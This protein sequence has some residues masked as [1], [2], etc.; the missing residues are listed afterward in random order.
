M[1]DWKTVRLVWEAS[2]EP[3]SNRSIKSA[4]DASGGRFRA[5]VL[6]NREGVVEGE[7]TFIDDAEIAKKAALLVEAPLAS[8]VDTLRCEL[9][10]FQGVTHFRLDSD[11]L[12][13]EI[14][15]EGSD[16]DLALGLFTGFV[17]GYLATLGPIPVLEIR[18]RTETA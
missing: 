2:L 18:T 7:L 5:R 9:R 16:T 15:V 14:V 13:F 12:R 6:S 17:E 4:I 8:L 1:S 3:G 11:A 10:V